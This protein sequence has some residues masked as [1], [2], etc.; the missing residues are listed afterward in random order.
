MPG[1]LSY[2]QA[3]FHASAGKL[4][5]HQAFPPCTH[6]LNLQLLFS[7]LSADKALVQTPCRVP[8]SPQA[9]PQPILHRA[10]FTSLGVPRGAVLHSKFNADRQIRAEPLKHSFH[11]VVCPHEPSYESYLS[12]IS[13]H[14]GHRNIPVNAL[15]R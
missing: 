5:W 13:Q 1:I 8:T 14:N 11:C 7:A 3:F 9:Q 10:T 6:G 4:C 12:F 2:L 15:Y